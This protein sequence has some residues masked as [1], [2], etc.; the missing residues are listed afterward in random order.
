MDLF[1]DFCNEMLCVADHRG[2]FLKLNP[3][4]TKALGW[5]LEELT[6]RP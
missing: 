2:Y 4:W 3:A 6:G 5:S 1:F